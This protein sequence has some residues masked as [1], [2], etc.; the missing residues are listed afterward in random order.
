MGPADF[1]SDIVSLDRAGN[2]TSI[3]VTLPLSSGSGGLSVSTDGKLLA[4]GAGDASGSSVYL[5]P[6]S[7]G[8]DLRRLASGSQPDF[9]PTN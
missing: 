5:L 2:V 9:K 1:T 7:G 8:A 4:Y 3:L 6:R